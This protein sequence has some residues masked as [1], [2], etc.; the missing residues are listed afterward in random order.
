LDSLIYAKH[1]Q[2]QSGDSLLD[3]GTGAGFPGLPLKIA[4]PALAVTLLEPSGKKTAFLH[5]MIGTLGFE[6]TVV[7]SRRVQ[8]F[9]GDPGNWGRFR[10]VVTRALNPSEIIPF[11]PSLLTSGGRVVLWRAQPLDFDPGRHGLSVVEEIGYRLPR[12]HGRRRLVVLEKAPTC[13]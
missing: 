7:V 5:H 8:E 3:V 9:A 2:V 11:I 6:R 1:L 4:C 10:H 12:G 13:S